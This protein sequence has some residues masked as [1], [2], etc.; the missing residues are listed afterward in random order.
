M[1]SQTV[2]LVV[3]VPKT[4]AD[5]VREALGRAGAGKFGNY[6][7]CSFTATGEGRFK[8]E[9]GADP[10]IGEIGKIEIVEEVQIE[11]IVDRAILDK[12]VKE[13]KQAHPYAEPIIEIWDIEVK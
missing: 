9:Q 11:T 7:H 8:P 12:V 10:S 5:S 1:K 2:K 3:N 4:H 6:T 13:L